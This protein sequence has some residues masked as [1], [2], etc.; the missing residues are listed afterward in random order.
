VE[1]VARA[2]AAGPS[3]VSVLLVGISI[4]L[5]AGVASCG[6]GATFASRQLIALAVQPSPVNAVQGGK[7]TFSATGTFDQA[8]STEANLTAQWVSSDPN[9]A[10]VDP[11][12]GIATCVGLGGPVNITA[13][14][15]G[16][17]GAVTSA[18]LLTCR[19]RPSG[20]GACEVDLNTRSLTGSCSGLDP[21]LRNHCRVAIDTVNCP[22]GQPAISP[23]T[24]SGCLPP[25][26]FTVDTATACSN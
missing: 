2:S 16:K 7:V 6:G 1:I 15:P 5:A 25:S 17:G 19:I 21:L 10:T 26:V 23:A 9:I 20:A 18:G 14:A 13:S 12:T 4:A 8:P 3:K 11:N 22:V 24:T